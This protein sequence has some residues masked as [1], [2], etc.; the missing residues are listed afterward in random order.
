MKKVT[1]ISILLLIFLFFGISGITFYF[2]HSSFWKDAVQNFLKD[3]LAIQNGLELQIGE[4]RGNPLNNITFKELRLLTPHHFQIA[5]IS[6]INL[7]YGLVHFILKKG[8]IRRVGIEGVKL[9][10]P[11]SLDSLTNY[12]TGTG[13]QGLQ[14]RIVIDKY[15]LANTNIFI[16]DTSSGSMV[17]SD[18]IQGRIFLN[19]DSLIISVNRGNIHTTALNETVSMRDI[20]LVKSGGRI[21]ISRATFL[22]QSAEITLGGYVGLDSI[23]DFDI[24]FDIENILLNERLKSTQE[25]FAA[26]DRI[27]LAGKVRF[28]QTGLTLTSSFDGQLLNNSLTQGRM[29]GRY[30]GGRFRFDNVSFQSTGQI[31]AMAVNG[32]LNNYAE[33]QI[34]LDGIDV[35]TWQKIPFHTAVNGEIRLRSKG[36]LTAPDTLIADLDFR[37]TLVDTLQID[38]IA[39]Q[40]RYVDGVFDITDTVRIGFKET[41]VM[42]EGSCNP[43][44]DSLHATVHVGSDSLD[45]FS[46]MVNLNELQGRVEGFLEASGRFSSPDFRGWLRGVGLGVANLRFDETIARFGLMNIQESRFGDIYIE[47][48]NGVTPFIKGGFP[49]AS[50][51]IR[52]EKDTSIIRS[53][54][55]TGENMNLELQGKMVK[56]SELYFNNINFEHNGNILKNIDPIQISSKAD[57]IS[58]AEVRFALNEGLVV[59]SGESVNRR[60]QTAVMNIS[61]LKVDP[62][63]AYLKGARGVAGLLDGL[64]VYTNTAATPVVYGRLQVDRANLIGKPFNNIRLE[65]RL[66]ENRIVLENFFLE[67]NDKGFMNGFGQLD[68][69][70]PRTDSGDFFK[71]SDLLN[72]QMQ[73]DNFDFG[74]LGSF[75]LPRFNKDGRLSGSFMITNTLENPELNYQLTLGDPVFDRITGTTLKANGIYRDNKLEFADIEL[76]DSYGK[77]RGSG[78]LPYVVAFKP[79]QIKFLKD[80]PMFMNFTLHTSSVEFL[81]KYIGSVESIEGD[82][83]ITLNLSGTPNNPVRSGNF[84]VKNSTVRV[85]ALENPVTGLTG[86]AILQ[87]NTMEIVSLDGY[88]VEPVSGSG[89]DRFRRALKKYTV[90]ILFPQSRSPD[91]PNVSIAGSID[92]TTFFK[93]VFNVR[94]DG[95]NIYVRTLLAEQEGILDGTFTVVG[96]DTMSIE[97]EVDINEFIIRNEFGGR[98][99]LIEED[100]KPGRVYT[101]INLHTIIPGN[102]YF[103]NSQLDCELEGEIWIIKNGPEPY[104]FS[105]TLDIRKGKFFYYGWEFDVVRG[106]LTF[107]PTEFNPTL[108]IEARVDLA[109]YTDNNTTESVGTPEEDYVTVML[110]GDLQNPTLTFDSN[111]KYNESDILMFLS[112]TQ[113]GSEEGLDQERISADAMN[114]FGMYFERQLERSISQISGLDEFELRT[115]GDLFFNQQPDQWSVSL[116]QKLAPNLY[117]KYERKLSLIEPTQIFGVEYRLNRNCSIAGEV[118]QDGSYRI[119]YLYKYRY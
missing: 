3:Q 34:R 83:D 75:I 114:V 105:G 19:P 41:S 86:S 12:L 35:R 44:A 72:L 68:C 109:S 36:L 60:V 46:E 4:L 14:R 8:G 90:D 13:S 37:N 22:N 88:L 55:V 67:D 77:A 5:E 33:A 11:A 87:N 91:E 66:V 52:F 27:N 16:G 53:F 38:F 21:I 50:L 95:D 116:G 57:T 15:E 49:L 48:S 82:Y 2:L 30:H 100:K 7:R 62:L 97:G 24:D 78:Y 80:E 56:L 119:N 58:L 26:D 81:S 94:M 23:P 51:I 61:Q 104:R 115:K 102:L 1:K 84:S 54:R 9:T 17:S 18:W 59:L 96:G 111:N 71:A 85:N 76:V 69:H 6:E 70:F 32:D 106:S 101:T 89:Y 10:F 108:D 43:T 40:L 63:N 98:Q 112:R 118:E 99:E 20:Q 42:L 31:I 110:S 73:F 79:L 92:F 93:P 28:D 65:A 107:D 25:L 117:F 113:L 39:G 64:I 74:I 103:R 45:V 47:A 29:S